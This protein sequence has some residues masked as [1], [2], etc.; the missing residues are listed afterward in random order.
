MKP[1]WIVF[2]IGG[3]IL[4]WHRCRQATIEKL[5]LSLDE[6]N[7]V[8]SKI[9]PLMEDGSITPEEGFKDILKNLNH[10]SD[11]EEI[12]TYWQSH[13]VP[14]N[15]TVDLIIKLQKQYRLA[16]CTNTWI[17]VLKSNIITFPS[18]FHNFQLFID[19]SVEKICKPNPK[20]Y[21][22]VESQTRTSGKD[23]FFID[24]SFSNIEGAKFLNWQTYLFDLKEDSG[25][26][27]CEKIA[28]IL[29]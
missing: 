10:N 17:N 24:D 27:S 23:I 29:L 21:Q 18:I 25:A 5:N 14:I 2:D 9:L 3:V 8:F 7:P 20:I 4:D 13:L 16:I 26:N 11:P 28:E 6:F 22:I 15:S 12:F 19:S 1:N